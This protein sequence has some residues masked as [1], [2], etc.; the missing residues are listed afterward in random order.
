LS[1]ESV[2][3]RLKQVVVGR[4]I[5]SHLAHHERLNRTTGLAVLSSDALSSVA[6]ATE[7]ILRTLLL[8]GAA[9][10]SLATPI[11]LVISG[12]LIVVAVSYRQTILAYPGGGGAYIVAK[13]NL[14]ETPGL[15]A[16]A[17]LLIDYVLTVAVSIAAGV[18]ALTSAFPTWH[19]NRV[20]VALGFVAL[21]AVGNLRGIRESGRIFAVPTYF[22]L[23]AVLGLIAA[24]VWRYLA[25]VAPPAA[26]PEA[27]ASL[28]TLSCCPSRSRSK[29]AFPSGTIFSPKSRRAA[30]SV[31]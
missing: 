29:W 16:A 19:V 15:V 6:Y 1:E 14:G 20:E 31:K 27:A 9:A 17:S 11:A 26:E 18:A 5:P 7:E 13:E 28:Q 2:L 24:G 23:A 4:P 21:I 25:G 10:L 30:S 8:A 3:G 12:L 22:F